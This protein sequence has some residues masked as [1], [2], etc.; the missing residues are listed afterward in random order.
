MP[1]M[2]RLGGS[3]TLAEME[4]LAHKIEA[5]EKA[6]NQPLA[7]PAPPS[8]DLPTDGVVVSE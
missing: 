8:L 5:A 3:H 7:D 4:A 1:R 2:P 6:A